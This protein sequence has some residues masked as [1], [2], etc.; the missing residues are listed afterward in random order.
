MP[1]QAR[2]ER[3][4]A[5]DALGGGGGRWREVSVFGVREIQLAWLR[6]GDRWLNSEPLTPDDL[7][8]MV[9]LVDFWTYT[10]INWPLRPRVV[11]EAR[12]TPGQGLVVVRRSPRSSGTSRTS[13]PP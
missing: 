7:R 6:G 8:G 1:P 3:P 4:V 13:A 11:G 12:H 2:L 9:V 5:G 10:C